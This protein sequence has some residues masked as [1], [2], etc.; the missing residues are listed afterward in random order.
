M[1][2]IT[3]LLRLAQ[4][5]ASAFGGVAKAASALRELVKRKPDSEADA[6]VG[7]LM[8]RLIAAQAAHLAMQEHLREVERERADA[9]E[10]ERHRPRY[11]MTHTPG[12][13]LVMRLKPGAEGGEPPH[14]CC[15]DCWQRGK[16]ALLHGS[17]NRRRCNACRV[18][19]F[20]GGRA[21]TL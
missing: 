3:A 17:G 12:G 18:E 16:R 11:A 8:G 2:D 1:D 21:E 10:F 4:E 14:D 13:A 19:F 5:S 9:A 15:A 7:E 20:V 6:L